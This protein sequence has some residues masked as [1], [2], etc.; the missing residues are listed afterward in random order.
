M[1]KKLQQFQDRHRSAWTIF[2]L[3]CFS[4]FI[5]LKDLFHG[6]RDVRFPLKLSIICSATSF[7]SPLGLYV[8][9]PHHFFSDPGP[10]NDQCPCGNLFA[11]CATLMEFAMRTSVLCELLRFTSH[12]VHHLLCNV[13]NPVNFVSRI[14]LALR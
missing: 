4:K 5:V 7:H 1:R 10:R 14:L 6:M 13:V 9:D 2:H 8:F 11:Y 12:F 3:L